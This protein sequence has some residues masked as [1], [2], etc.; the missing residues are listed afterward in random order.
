MKKDILLLVDTDSETAAVAME[1]AVEKHLDLHFAPR[2]RDAFHLFD[3][4]L[5]EV[6]VVILDL[7]RGAQSTGLLEALAVHGD[8]PPIVALSNFQEMIPHGAAACLAKPVSAQRLRHAIAE[9]IHDA[10]IA[11]ECQCDRWGHPCPNCVRSD[12]TN[13]TLEPVFALR[14]F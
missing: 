2:S 13:E 8:A 9:A 10:P 11:V 5:E 7:D 12:E 6:A 14:E 1:V 4:G 3:G